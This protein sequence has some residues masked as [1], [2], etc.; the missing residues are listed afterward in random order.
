MYYRVAIQRDDGSTWKWKSTPL[1]SLDTLFQFLRL[2]RALPQDGL[3][4]FSSCSCEDLDGQLVRENKG[5]GSPSI[6]A[7]QF[8][9]ERRIC[10]GEVV[11]GASEQGLRRNQGTA[12][13]AVS[14]APSSTESSK[15]VHLSH[16]IGIR[17][18]ESRR[19]ELEGGTGGDH[20]SPYTFTLP[21]S[22]PQVLAW[23]QLLVGAQ[24]GTLQS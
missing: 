3:R 15:G 21:T 23:I 9:Q 8:L 2:Y 19:V 20:D 10:S 12:S 1:T 18:L 16:E 22:M 7:A 6:T 13:I 14:T 4:V 24:V 5:L 17:S 11:G